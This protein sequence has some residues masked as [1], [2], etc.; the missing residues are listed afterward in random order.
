MLQIS[1]SWTK[2]TGYTKEDMKNFDTWLNTAYGHGAKELSRHVSQ[3][4]KGKRA[5]MNIE[6]PIRTKDNRVRYWSYSASAPG[7]L[8]SGQR[9]VIGM[10]EDITDRKR[11]DSMKDEFIGLVSHELKTPLTVITG[12]ISTAMDERVPED[13]RRELLEDAAWGAES[14]GNILD[15]LLELSRYQADR[16]K[17]DKIAASIKQIADETVL[18]TRSQH[19]RHRISIDISSKIPSIVVDPVRI[20]RILSNLIDNA[21][22]Y[23]PEGSAVTVFA[24]RNKNEIIIGVSDQGIGITPEDQEGLFEPFGRVETKIKGIGLG[25]V[26]CKRLVEAH[27][28]RIWVESKPRRGATFLF[29]I[30]LKTEEPE[31]Q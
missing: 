10:A 22:K 1:R 30:P 6:F 19:P 29:T 24:R 8:T 11:V 23:S 26:V 5:A 20:T 13:E 9:F 15:N 12:A 16:L 31:G 18:A 14:L 21:C 25:L 28:G 17:L 2:L 3:L 7:T 4:F 27:G